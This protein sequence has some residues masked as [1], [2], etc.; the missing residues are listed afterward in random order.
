MYTD[1]KYDFLGMPARLGVFLTKAPFPLSRWVGIEAFVRAGLNASGPHSLYV[2]QRLQL[3]LLYVEI[4][5]G[6]R[7]LG[8]DDR[9]LG[10]EIGF[11]I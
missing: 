3:S 8:A 6:G 2:G 1:A 7:G 5:A 11:G 9:S 10:I 4:E